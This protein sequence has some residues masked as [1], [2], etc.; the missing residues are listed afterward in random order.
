MLTYL[1]IVI[2]FTLYQMSDP[3]YLK[4]IQKHSKVTG[5]HIEDLILESFIMSILFC[6][7]I[8]IFGLV[9]NLVEVYNN[10]AHS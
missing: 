4:R 7:I 5:Y 8:V 9:A 10:V 1:L 3:S 6:P 2:L